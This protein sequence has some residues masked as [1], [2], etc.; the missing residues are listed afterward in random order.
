MP[1]LA[2]T[3]ARPAAG[4]VHDAVEGVLHVA[5]GIGIFDSQHEGTAE[6]AGAGAGEGPRRGE[7]RAQGIC[8]R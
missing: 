5:S 8:R 3:R 6:V 7:D 4:G 2:A 1:A